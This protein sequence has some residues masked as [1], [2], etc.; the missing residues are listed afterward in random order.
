[1]ATARPVLIELDP[2]VSPD[3]YPLL[4]PLGAVYGVAGAQ[5]AARSLQG[6]AIFQHLIYDHVERELGADVREVETSHQLLWWRYMDAVF[7]AARGKQELARKALAAASKLDAHD[8][9]LVALRGAINALPAGTPLDV[10][11][12]LTFSEP[13]AR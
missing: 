4:L 5:A 8:A 9:Q 13:P 7:Y 12:F 1:L 10:R 3:V 2:H 11:P 6:A